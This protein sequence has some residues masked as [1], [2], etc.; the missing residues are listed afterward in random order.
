MGGGTYWEQQFPYVLP[1]QVDLVPQVPSVL[2]GSVAVEVDDVEVLVEE[3]CLTVEDDFEELET[4]EDL[5]VDEDFESDG[6]ELDNFEVDDDLERDEDLDD[7]TTVLVVD[8]SV[9][10][11]YE[12]VLN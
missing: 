4:V 6:L 8:F 7:V 10:E 2:T 9:E 1:R 5:D 11:I 12:L 3:D